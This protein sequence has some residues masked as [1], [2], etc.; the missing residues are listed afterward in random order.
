M[1]TTA[2]VVNE[3]LWLL[4]T[5]IGRTAII[6]LPVFLV[7]M[8]WKLWYYYI[9]AINIRDTKWVLL[10]IKLPREMSKSPKAMEVVLGVFYQTFEGNKWTRFTQGIVRTYFSLELVSLGG[11]VHF[12]IYTPKFFKNLVESQIY[13][14]YPG[15]EISE[16]EDYTQNIPAYGTPQSNHKIWG[17]EF[18]FSKEDA[19]PIKTYVDYGLDKDPKEEFKVDPIT[20]VLEFLGSITPAEQ[21]WM[22]ILIVATRTRFHKPGT[23]FGKQDWKGD[24]AVLID[25]LMK[26][27]QFKPGS[28]PNAI[29][30][31]A[32]ALSPGERTVVEAIERSM[33]KLAFDCGFRAIY[34]APKD[35]FKDANIPGMGGSIKQFNSANL[36][37]F[38]YG[39]T[40]GVDEQWKDFKGIRVERMKRK[41]FDAY[42]RR[43]YFYPPYV[44]K[45][46]V[47]N[48]E[49]LATIYHFPGQVAA[50]PTLAKIESKRGEPPIDLPI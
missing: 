36:N 3:S 24:A 28:D 23:W 17:V 31:G 44:G 30:F 35:Q 7:Y 19:Y 46:M 1:L 25:K 42:R 15:I 21:V 34:I 45:P 13:S 39:L 38:K 40:T 43:S 29:P 27:E 14:Q 12:Y 6:W 9:Q 8:A 16:A 11:T 18:A 26:R 20:P 37:G 49:E 10:D 33:D 4:W 48:T 47:L 22:Q 41:I 2:S 5:T 32:L 50:T